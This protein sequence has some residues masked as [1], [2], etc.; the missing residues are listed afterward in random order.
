MEI[1]ESV[2]RSLIDWVQFTVRIPLADVYNLI[3]IPESEFVE[4]P[5]GLYFYAKQKKCGDIRVLW[6]S[7]NGL[8]MGVHVQFSGQGCR[9][10]ETFY[11]GDWINL[12]ASVLAQGGHFTRLDLAVDEIRYNNEKPYFT[13]RQ[14]IKKTLSGETRSKWKH[15]NRMQK[16]RIM[17]GASLGDTGYFGSSLSDI[18]ARWYEKDK[19]RINAGKE[20]EQQLTTW[21]R[22]ELQLADD[23]AQDAAVALVNGVPLG[24][25]FFRLIK[26][27][28]TFTNRV[29]GDSNKSRWPVCKWWL[30]FLG[31]VE[32]LQLARKAPDKTIDQKKEWLDRQVLPTF[33]EVWV[34]M[35]SPGEEY[36]KEMITEGLER[37]SDAQW[38]RAEIHLDKREKENEHFKR[39]KQRYMDRVEIRTAERIEKRSEIY[40][41]YVLEMS[42]LAATKEKEPYR[43]ALLD[44]L[45]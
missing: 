36:F 5:H 26:N 25:I 17:D 4:M 34:A 39:R 29:K 9:E 27:Y 15:L 19:E 22:G 21:N 43:A 42:E 20:L 38:A 45:Q 1:R 28:L 30:D 11:N 31:D 35:G 40:N 33:A 44:D 18:Q 13:V 41:A 16:I 14:L 12:F 10:Y 2:L 32:K 7:T 24:E 23:R 6:Q 8:D 3:G 37:M